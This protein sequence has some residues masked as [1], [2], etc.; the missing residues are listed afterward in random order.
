M[1]DRYEEEQAKAARLRKD[2]RERM[3]K[4]V[5]KRPPGRFFVLLLIGLAATVVVRLLANAF[6]WSQTT[7]TI[8]V[9]ILVLVLC[10]VGLPVALAGEARSSHTAGSVIGRI[11]GR[12]L[13]RSKTNE[14]VTPVPPP[15]V[16]GGPSL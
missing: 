14:T 13:H 8:V 2:Q 12:L 10:I 16:E 9:C 5:G 1:P 15:N 3:K 11:F 4:G 6:S 7:G